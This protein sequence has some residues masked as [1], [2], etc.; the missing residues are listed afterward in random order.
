MLI[1]GSSANGDDATRFAL[2][3]RPDV[4]PRNGFL[5][6]SRSATRSRVRLRACARNASV[7]M[8][9]RGFQRWSVH[10]LNRSGQMSAALITRTDIFDKAGQELHSVDLQDVQSAVLERNGQMS[11]IRKR[12]GA[13]RV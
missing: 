12:A 9:W 2:A 3:S 1:G 13:R 5:L 11:L 4:A 8:R 6:L 10:R 7:H